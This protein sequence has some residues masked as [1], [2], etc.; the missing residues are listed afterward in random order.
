MNA[1]RLPR[2][3]SPSLDVRATC[4]TRSVHQP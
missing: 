1:N 3:T 4:S 2:S